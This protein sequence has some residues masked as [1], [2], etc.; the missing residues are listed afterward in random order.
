MPIPALVLSGER[1]GGS[2]LAR[3]FDVPAGALVPVAGRP[4]IARGIAALRASR[5]VQGG[6]LCGPEKSVVAASPC[7]Q[8]LLAPG[9]FVWMAPEAGPAASVAAALEVLGRFPVL[10]TTGDHALLTPA[11]IDTFCRQALHRDEDALIGLVPFETVMA[12]FPETHRTALRFAGGSW[13]GTNLFLFRT[14]EGLRAARFWREV[15]ALR[16]HPWKIARALGPV[17]LLRYLA[18]RLDLTEALATLAERSG[19]RIGHVALDEPRVAVDVDT[20]GDQKLAERILLAE[21]S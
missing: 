4:A 18:R 1:P 13:C 12:A 17:V 20:V 21:H 7:L 9:D 11:V 8:S 10:V 2:S 19:C 6:R 5:M 14:R 16:K 3:A 15:E